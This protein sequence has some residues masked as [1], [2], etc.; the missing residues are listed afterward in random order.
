MPQD[1]T[2]MLVFIAGVVAIG[3][4]AVGGLASARQ[5]VTQAAQNIQNGLPSRPTVDFISASDVSN[6][7][8]G[9]I[10]NVNEPRIVFEGETS[11]VAS[12][13]DVFLSP[14]D[15]LGGDPNPTQGGTTEQVLI[16]DTVHTGW[17]PTTLG[18]SDAIET[19]EGIAAGF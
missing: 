5:R 6:P 14:F 9:F 3:V 11:T 17:T 18:T 1:N 10:G 8:T 16:G 13:T 2:R 7:E 4:F 19:E 15:A 12:R